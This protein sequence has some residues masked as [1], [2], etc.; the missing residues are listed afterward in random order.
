MR[1]NLSIFIDLCFYALY[2][3]SRGNTKKE[4]SDSG[5]YQRSV[6]NSY[7]SKEYKL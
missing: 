1:K 7:T 2:N 3:L 6:H 5:H 4:T